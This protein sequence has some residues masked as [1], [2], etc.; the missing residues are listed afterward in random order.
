MRRFAVLAFAIVVA[1]C[2]WQYLE[3]KATLFKS[4]LMVLSQFKYLDTIL[5]E[6]RDIHG[7]YPHRLEELESI[8]HSDL[9]VT[10]GGWNDDWGWPIV[11]FTVE[12]RF[13]LI[14]VGKDGALD[15][16]SRAPWTVPVESVN[17]CGKPS[18]DQVLTS[19]GW[20]F[21]CYKQR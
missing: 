13:I 18:H 10:W 21:V 14:S 1:I 8:V 20:I 3:Y 15:E 7:N 17:V 11:Y 2:G 6:Y 4:Q 5:R 19:E 16:S 9:L 12:D